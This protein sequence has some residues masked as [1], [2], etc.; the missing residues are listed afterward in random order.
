MPTD[1]HYEAFLELAVATDIKNPAP[2][3]W[4]EWRETVTDAVPPWSLGPEVNHEVC[5]IRKDQFDLIQAFARAYYA[6]TTAQ[7]RDKFARGSRRDNHQEGRK[8]LIDYFGSVWESWGINSIVDDCLEGSEC[9]ISS[10]ALPGLTGVSY[11]S[12]AHRM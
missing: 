4:V 8:A 12:D 7:A 3:C 5:K 11:A 1:V 9:T 2:F 10:M 6:C